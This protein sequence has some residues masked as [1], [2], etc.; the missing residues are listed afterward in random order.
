MKNWW[1]LIFSMIFFTHSWFAASQQM[2]KISVI[3]NNNI[4][5]RSDI[6]TLLQS[7]KLSLKQSH[8]QISN[9][10]QLRNQVI[11]SLIMH[12]IQLQ[13]AQQIGITISERDLD[14]AIAN[15]AYK[16]HITID[17]LRKRL[18]AEGINYQTYRTQIRNAIQTS[19][20]RN[21]E[22]KRRI[23]ILPQEVESLAKQIS[24][25]TDEDIELNISHILISLPEN[26]SEQK[27]DK[28]KKQAEKIVTEIKVNNKSFATLALA[29]SSDPTAREGGKIGWGKLVDFPS[30]FSEQLKTANKGDIIGPICSGVGFH[31]L[32]VNDIRNSNK[33]MLITEMHIRHILLKSSVIM[34]DK[35]AQEKL[36]S[37]RQE[38]KSGKTDFSVIAREISEDSRS[39]QQG[40]DLGWIANDYRHEYDFLDALGRLKKDD[41]SQPIHS[42][43][44]WH[45]IQLIDRR[46]VDRTDKILKEQAYQMLIK[47]KFLEEL[48]PWLQELRATTYVKILDNAN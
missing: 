31:I 44:G 15:I 24:D 45:L 3:V 43:L 32:K 18:V 46:I 13:M 47:R 14:N 37:I 12:D 1:K 8:Q 40:G 39:A 27:K 4:I 36:Q 42:S 26:T 19:E 17:Q 48:Q 10:N 9:E 5:L 28:A 41:I 21:N 34:T 29:Y 2:N 7:V 6:D 33:K 23:K 38:I 25:K 11:E 30:L 16:N 35:Q 20:V 22:V